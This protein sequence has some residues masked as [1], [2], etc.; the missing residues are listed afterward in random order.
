MMRLILAPKSM[1]GIEEKLKPQDQKSAQKI[2]KNHENEK[3]C[4]S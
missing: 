1:K 3:W 2:S 4:N